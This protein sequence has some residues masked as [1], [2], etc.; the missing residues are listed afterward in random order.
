LLSDA[1]ARAAGVVTDGL[2]AQRLELR[3]RTEPLDTWTEHV[4]PSVAAD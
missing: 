3:G 1:T 4:A 2:V